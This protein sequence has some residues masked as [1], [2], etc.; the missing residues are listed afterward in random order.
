MKVFVF[1]Q[2]EAKK[3]RLCGQKPKKLPAEECP[4][5]HIAYESAPKKKSATA[6]FHG[7]RVLL[8][9]FVLLLFV[10]S[11]ILLLFVL[12]LLTVLLL[13]AVLLLL[14]VLLLTVNILLCHTFFSL[15]GLLGKNFPVSKYVQLACDNSADCL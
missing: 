9:E 3:R 6:A 14:T 13:L 12:L 1:Y 8:S 10:L 5:R 2:P 7:C 15:I 4:A 11:A